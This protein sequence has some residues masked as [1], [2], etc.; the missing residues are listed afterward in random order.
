[1]GDKEYKSYIKRKL[2]LADHTYGVNPFI[3]EP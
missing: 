1:M 2:D 3:L